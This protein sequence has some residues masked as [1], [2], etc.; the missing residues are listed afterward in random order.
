M[1]FHNHVLSFEQSVI[2]SWWERKEIYFLKTRNLLKKP[3]T[4]FR[5][6]VGVDLR[7]FQER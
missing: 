7:I 6:G 1:G 4:T 2:S 3:D 5:K